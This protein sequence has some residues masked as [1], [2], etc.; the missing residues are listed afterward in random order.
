M[1]YEVFVHDRQLGW[2]IYLCVYVGLVSL[3]RLSLATSKIPSLAPEMRV[4]KNLADFQSP[5]NLQQ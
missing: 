4:G 2:L 5:I 1:P 3:N